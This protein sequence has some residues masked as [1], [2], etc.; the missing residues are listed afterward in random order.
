[1]PTALVLSITLAFHSCFRG[2]GDG[3]LDV[4]YSLYSAWSSLVSWFLPFF[5]LGPALNTM[6]AFL[7]MRSLAEVRLFISQMTQQYN[8]K[9]FPSI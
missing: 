5:P 9:T 8:S 6:P 7:C 4:L 3:Q 1:M 2:L